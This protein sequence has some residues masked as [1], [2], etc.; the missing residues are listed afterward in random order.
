MY[1]YKITN[2]VNNKVYIGKTKKSIE[3]RFRAHMRGA[4]KKVNRHLY[5]AMNHYGYDN[6]EISLVE[7]CE[8]LDDLNEKEKFWIKELNTFSPNGYNMTIGGDG[9][10]TL[11]HWTEEEKR[12]LWD[13]QSKSRTGQ[14]RTSEQKMNMSLSAKERE[15]KKSK[16]DKE[17]ISKKISNTLKQKYQSGECVANTPKLYGK[18]HPQFIEVDIQNVLELIYNC[19]TLSQISEILNVSPYGIRSRLVEK[20]GKNYLEWRNE[21]GIVGPLSKPRRTG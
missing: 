21:Y 16:V 13:R 19:K 12:A 18:D 15:N 11:L 1:I 17:V 9:G 8:S 4:K 10:D 5:D 2:K 14:K 7:Q 3:S 6:F 20:T